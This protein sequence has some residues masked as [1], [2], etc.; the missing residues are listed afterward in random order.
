MLSWF[1][2][3]A[4]IQTLGALVLGAMLAFPA[5]VY[6]GWSW[7][8]A[9]MWKRYA[10]EMEKAVE[11]SHIMA[12]ADKAQAEKDRQDHARLEATLEAT[13]HEARKAPNQCT[14]SDD[15]RRL[16]RQLS[17]TAQY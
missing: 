3:A 15:D 7:S 9:D 6:K 8:Q 12:D 16:L 4:W 11:A 17:S 14:L 2:P 13:V 10:L 5:G 1:N